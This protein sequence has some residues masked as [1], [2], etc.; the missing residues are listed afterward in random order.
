[1]RQKDDEN[2]NK[3]LDIHVCDITKCYLPVAEMHVIVN[4]WNL[5]DPIVDKYS[6]ESS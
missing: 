4:A 6:L 3:A 5:P 1:M 2:I